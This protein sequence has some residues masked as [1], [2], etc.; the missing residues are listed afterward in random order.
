[1]SQSTTKI[2]DESEH[3]IRIR[4]DDPLANLQ[5]AETLYQVG[6]ATILSSKYL[7]PICGFEILFLKN[8]TFERAQF[9]RLLNID[10]HPLPNNQEKP[11]PF[12]ISTRADTIFKAAGICCILVLLGMLALEI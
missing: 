6:G 7:P 11:Q 9:V 5:E 2:L 12:G 4:K 1:M 10:E 3:Y 8:E